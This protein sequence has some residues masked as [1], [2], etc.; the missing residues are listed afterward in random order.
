MQNTCTSTQDTGITQQVTKICC[1]LM[2]SNMRPWQMS[3]AKRKYL[4]G[5]S[6][7]FTTWQL[8]Y[9]FPLLRA[10]LFGRRM[11]NWRTSTWETSTKRQ[12]DSRNKWSACGEYRYCLQVITI[13]LLVF[14]HAS[15]KVQPQTA[16]HVSPA[17]NCHVNLVTVG[18]DS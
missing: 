7:V 4:Q 17:V 11:Q 3:S 16:K 8:H 10:R 1:G 12:L 14:I 2:C 15:P 13:E 6:I 5:I 9:R 18:E